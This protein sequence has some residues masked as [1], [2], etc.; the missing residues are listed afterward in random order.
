KLASIR[1]ESSC[2]STRPK[3]TANSLAVSPRGSSSSAK[4]L[5]RVSAMIR[6]RTRSSNMNRT[7]VPSSA[8]ASPLTR[9]RTSISDRGRSASP[10][11]P[12]RGRAPPPRPPHR[13]P[14]PPPPRKRAPSHKRQ[15]RRRR[16]IEPLRIID[17]A[18]Q[19]MLLRHLGEQTQ[20]PEADKEAIGRGPGGDA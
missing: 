13:T 18:Q 12:E 7:A 6:S 3:P 11:P 2:E 19:R 16:L 14:G 17:H 20:R 5:P 15:R 1:P 9:P 8:R 4:G 10:P